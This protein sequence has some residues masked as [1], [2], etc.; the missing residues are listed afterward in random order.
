M[1][2]IEPGHVYD[3]E[4]FSGGEFV[5]L[6]FLNR[7]PAKNDHNGTLNQEVLR[8][9]IDRVIYLNMEESWPLNKEIVYHLRMA[10]VLHEARALIRK[11]EKGTLTPEHIDVA[12]CDQHFLLTEK[13]R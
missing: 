9:L 7:G 8:A 12:D 5:R 13:A 3:L 11:V 6:T 1:N 10:L 4:T 2:V